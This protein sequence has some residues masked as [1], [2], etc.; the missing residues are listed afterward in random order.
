MKAYPKARIFVLI[1]SL[2][3]IFPSIKYKL[4]EVS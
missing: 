4:E 3:I 1:I 2:I